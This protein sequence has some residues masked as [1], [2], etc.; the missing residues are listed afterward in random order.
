MLASQIVLDQSDGGQTGGST[1]RLRFVLASTTRTTDATWTT[2]T[3]T[4]SRRA[5]RR[6]PRRCSAPTAP[7][8][9][10]AR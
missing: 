1:T 10:A 3:C 4:R 8:R 2:P 7:A 6:A 5:S 9:S